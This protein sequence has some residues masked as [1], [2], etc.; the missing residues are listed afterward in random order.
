M[1]ISILMNKKCN[2]IPSVSNHWLRII[3]LGSYRHGMP[4][5]I[6]EKVSAVRLGGEAE[7]MEN[8]FS[9][10][11]SLLTQPFRRNENR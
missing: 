6:S 11:N 4:W 2:Y 1:C 8:L 9:N 5:Y 3:Q 7:E 10:F